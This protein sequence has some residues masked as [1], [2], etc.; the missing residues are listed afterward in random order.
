MVTNKAEY[1]ILTLVDLARN[2]RDR[3]V[4]S[5]EVA[6][7]QGIPAKYMPQLMAMLTRAGWVTSARGSGGGVRLA[8]DPK[9]ITVKDVIELSGDPILIRTCVGTKPGCARSTTCPLHPVWARAQEFLDA[10]LRETSIADLAAKER[11]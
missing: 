1:L 7:R 2:A 6:E 4:L 8:A 3:Y 11:S 10:S 9:D 5:R